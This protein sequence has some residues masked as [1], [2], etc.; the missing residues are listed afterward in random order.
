MKPYQAYVKE[1]GLLIVICIAGAGC[2]SVLLGQDANWDLKN[3]HI[4]NAWALL[5]NRFDI[6]IFAAGIQTYFN[7]ILDLPYY[8]L[9]LIWWDDKPRTVAFL[10]GLPYGLLVFL[11]IYS[12]RLVLVDLKITLRYQGL[13][14]LLLVGFGASGAAT[15]QQI[16]TTFNEMQVA[17]FIIGGVALLLSGLRDIGQPPNQRTVFWGGLMFGLAAGMKL[18]ACI[19]APAAAISLFAINEK[20]RRAMSTLTIFSMAWALGFSVTF[21]WWAVHLYRFTGNP[22]FPMFENVF[23]TSWLGAGSGMDAHFKPK[24]F[25]QAILY[26]FFWIDSTVPTVAE[27]VFSDPRFAVALIALLVLFSVLLL[28]RIRH[29]VLRH[30]SVRQLEIPKT[31][32]FVLVFTVIAYVSWLSAFSILRYAISI[33]VLLGL[34]IAIC[35]I[36]CA[37]FIQIKLSESTLI[38]CL[39]LLLVGVSVKT[40]YPEWGRSAY[41][42]AVLDVQPVTLTSDSLLIVLGPPQA[43]VLPSIAKQN[44]SVQFVGITDDLLNARGFGMWKKISQRINNFSGSIYTMVRGDATERLSILSELNFRLDEEDCQ[45]FATNIDRGFKICALHKMVSRQE[46]SLK[47]PLTSMKRGQVVITT[48]TVTNASNWDWPAGGVFPVHLSYHWIDR[49]QKIVVFDGE[50][51]ILP[52][53]VKAGETVKVQAIIKAPDQPGDYVLR[54]TMVQESVAWFDDRGVKAL[55]LSVKVK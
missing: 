24:S 12:T 14:A 49:S 11:L 35:L 23:G 6:D 51:T 25:L 54:M 45:V 29:A 39:S 48:A 10:M 32:L 16:G 1:Y 3:Y 36:V 22:V 27:P 52:R 42:T 5:H 19:Y 38:L 31:S 8:F 55:D 20:K 9:A 53:E 43:Y 7:P 21:G 28:T 44:P 37:R 4:Y 47:P 50:R 34:T 41:G 17:V 2:L 33:E 30:S 13:V 26:P 40:K 15:I 18:T 46:I